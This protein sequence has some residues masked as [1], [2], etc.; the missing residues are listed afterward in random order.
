MY[1]IRISNQFLIDIVCFFVDV[2]NGCGVF[3]SLTEGDVDDG[4]CGSFK[5]H[6]IAHN[7]FC[8]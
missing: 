1:N 2:E 3:V 6:N 4:E 5:E 8:Q 7:V